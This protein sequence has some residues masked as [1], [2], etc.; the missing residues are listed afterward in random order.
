MTTS[1][2]P[3]VERRTSSQQMINKFVEERTRM[4]SLYSDLAATQ[5]PYKD[6]ASISELLSHFCEALIDYTADA[7][8][9]LYRYIDDRRERRGNVLAV[10]SQSYP[11]I[12]DTTQDI[13]DF[14]DKY[15]SAG[16]E[17]NID[18]L[19]K[20]LSVLG[21]RL[22]DR[23]AIEDRVIDALIAGRQYQSQHGM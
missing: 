13:L 23:I 15:D 17:I 16:H 10:A 3:V 2:A 8:F 18:M 4:L 9:R 22:A 19:E 1:T 14:N 11:V 21:E 20:D 5:H 6:L 7:H 12:L